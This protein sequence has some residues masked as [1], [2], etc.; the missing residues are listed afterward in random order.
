MSN[1]TV[2]VDGQL[3]YTYPPHVTNRVADFHCHGV[4]MTSTTVRLTK[5]TSSGLDYFI[6]LCE[7]EVYSKFHNIYLPCIRIELESHIA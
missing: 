6:S 5:V 3:C 1:I 4:V 7:F 2:T